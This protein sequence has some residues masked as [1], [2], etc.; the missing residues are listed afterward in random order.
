MTNLDK[1]AKA[2]QV[3]DSILER[4]L[5]SRW[6]PPILVAALLLAAYVGWWVHG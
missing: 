1:L 2:E 5:K 4:I 3:T 6:S